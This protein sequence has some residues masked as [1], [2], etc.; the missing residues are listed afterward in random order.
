MKWFQNLSFR[1]KLMLPLGLAALVFVLFAWSTLHRVALLGK[2]VD[3]LVQVNVPALVDLLE[4]DRDLYQALVAERSMIFI[5]PGTP[6]FAR[7]I[8]QQ[9]ENIR[10]AHERFDRA[11][12]T[13][14]DSHL[15]DLPEL[16][17]RIERFRQLRESWE[18]LTVR[19]PRERDSDASTGRANAVELTLNEVLTA[20]DAMRDQLDQL[21]GALLDA[22]TQVAQDTRNEVAANR[23]QTLMLLALGL[24]LLA[25]SG[26]VL[27]RLILAPM[28]GILARVHDLA[29]GEG[30]LTV[31]LAVDGRDEIGQLALAF[32]RLLTRLQEL[33]AQAIDLA[34]RVD[35]ASDRLASVSAESD[36]VLMEQ[37]TQIQLV[38]TAMHEMAATVNEVAVN[39]AQAAESAREADSGVRTGARVVG[40]AASAMESL[41]DVVTRAAE[42]ISA[43][44]VE[45]NRIGAVLEVIKGIAEQTSLLALNAAI[46]AARAG[47]SGRGFAVV[48]SEVRNLAS[49]TQQS[50][51]EIEA[52][53]ASLQSS[54]RNVVSVM[55]KGRGMT[56]HSLENAFQASQSLEAITQAVSR[57][58]EM[59]AQIASATEEQSAV[60]EEIN[61]NTLRIQDL[62]E[63]AV[64]ASRQTAQERG[65]LV[66]LARALRAGLARFRV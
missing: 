61:G 64:A 32:N 6:L 4:A 56:R 9:S 26:G 14:L 22:L 59:S 33:V 51:G 21:Q 10:Q 34:S 60:T 58:N 45:S 63:H 8:E 55:D 54:A 18:A 27:P 37:L 41:A 46:E 1:Y 11:A 42:A 38:A 3:R 40:E 53:I 62:A 16:A 17:D 20:F 39:T 49:R 36:Q 30:D 50:T 13:V 52:M 19:I 15:A 28:R 47:E 65:D 23:T 48:A 57:I 31:R 24:G 7:M 29:E 44:E 25:L 12:S 5:E 66:E 35:A 2:D 43:L